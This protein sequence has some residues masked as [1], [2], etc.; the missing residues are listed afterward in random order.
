MTQPSYHPN[1]F[2]TFIGL[3]VDKNSF[4][5]TVQDKFQ[6]IKSKKMPSN[7]EHLY[8]Y[9]NKHFNHKNVICA[10]EAGPTGFHLYDYLSKQDILCL[11]TSPSSIPTARNARVKN[12]RID[13]IKIADHLMSGKLKP[14]R[15]PEGAY[16]ELRDLIKICKNYTTDRK[17]ARQ[18]IKAL[19]LYHN[20]YPAMKDPDANWSAN[21]I[22]D[23][24]NIDCSFAVRQRLD[25][26][27]EDLEYARKKLLSVHRTLKSFCRE[28]DQIN[29][30]MNYLQSIPG[31]GFTIAVMLLGK[32]G[33]PQNL[34]NPRELAAFVGLTPKE[35]SSGD[36][37][38]RGPIT[39]LGDK[40]LR[41][42]L[43]EAAWV[44]IRKDT[45]L[46]QFFNRIKNKNHPKAASRIAITAVA[47][48]LTQIIYRVLKD[49]RNY[50]QH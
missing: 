35:N 49:E 18:R 38:N 30:Y 8:N 23:L 2:E 42:L 36:S 33:D 34:H 41:Y 14:I 20:L 5:Y 37:V 21:Y 7:P 46:N 28:N 22:E 3:D 26:L 24:K 32:I 48:K 10:Y 19:L 29:Q 1:N 6:L 13:S 47:R 43:V 16:R 45:Q 44:A 9:I 40:T 11:I 31:I 17:T 4:S 25:M 39:H 27:I 50:I 15:V 12:N